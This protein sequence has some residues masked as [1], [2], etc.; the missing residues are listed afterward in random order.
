MSKKT[1]IQSLITRLETVSVTTQD[2]NTSTLHVRLFN[3]QIERKR[4]GEGIV[5]QTPACFVE[6]IFSNGIPIGEGATAYDVVF[7]LHVEIENYNTEG[8]HDSAWQA[9]D[10]VDA[11]HRKLNKFKPT[12]CSHLYQAGTQVDSSHDNTVVTILEYNAHFVD[13]VASITDTELFTE[14]TIDGPILQIDETVYTGILPQDEDPGLPTTII[15]SIF[16]GYGVGATV[17][18]DGDGVPADTLGYNGDY[19]LDNLTGDV[20]R[21]VSG[22]YVYRCNIKGADGAA[23]A[24]GGGFTNVD[25]TGDY[26]PNTGE[27]VYIGE[28]ALS[29]DT[30]L[31]LSSLNHEGDEVWIINRNKVWKVQYTGQPVYDAFGGAVA[32][33]YYNSNVYLRYVSGQLRLMIG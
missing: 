30:L 7:R 2:S 11:I 27:M 1:A 8:E 14:A 26:K 6:P 3:D 29:G 18:R 13:M 23:G 9:M 10:V 16:G 20:Y 22:V 28:N 19:Y 25:I 17:W 4:Q 21:K 33:S 24:N 31:D 15:G 32:L 5:Y 12:A